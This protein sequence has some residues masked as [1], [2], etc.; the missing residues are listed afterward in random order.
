MNSPARG[1][2]RPGVAAVVATLLLVGC[3]PDRH[4]EQIRSAVREGDLA[5][6]TTVLN[7]LHGTA[8]SEALV[9]LMDQ[10][11][12]DHLAGRLDAAAVSFDQAVPMVDEQRNRPVLDSIGR[13]VANDTA[14]EFQGRAYENLQVDW[15]RTLNHLTAAELQDGAWQPTTLLFARQPQ[16]VPMRPA[17]D[18]SAIDH[19]ERAVNSARRLTIATAK[20]EGDDAGKGKALVDD[21]ATRLLAAATVMAL[22]RAERGE[23]DEQFAAAMLTQAVKLY[24]E[25]AKGY[26][27]KP[28]RYEVKGVPPLVE[29]LRLRQ[30]ASYD[31]SAVADEG[32]LAAARLPAGHGSVL[33]LNHVGFCARIEPLQIGLLAVG[34]APPAPT[35]AER[36]RGVTS[37]QF[38]LGAIGLYAKGPGSEIARS[39]VALPVPG[40]LVQEALAPGGAT[41]IGFEVPV[42]RPDRPIGTPAGLMING[43]APVRFEVVGDLDAQAR[44]GLRDEQPSIVLR[45]LIRV[46]AKQGAVAVGAKAVRESNSGE[47]GLLAFLVNLIGSSLATWTESADLRCWLT[48]QDHVEGVLVDLPEGTHRLVVEG[49]AGRNDLGE[50]RVSPGRLTILPFRTF[51]PETEDRTDP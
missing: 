44:A 8:S 51:T 7:D 37:T 25:T 46:L 45:T 49:A 27:D 5:K 11:L 33:V 23:S 35:A 30:L 15:W 28:W 50:V 22:P 24:S 42:H 48:L 20:R 32:G 6:A 26:A 10:G 12:I 39:W 4:A 43:G 47:A 29:R 16:T 1:P 34:F 3:G 21:P 14:S 2:V 13:W 40:W 17:P 31:P 18:L 38:S 9:R 36:A 41:V 19:R